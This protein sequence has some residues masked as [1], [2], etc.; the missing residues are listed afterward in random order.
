MSGL[1]KDGFPITVLPILYQSYKRS[2][3][4]V[5]DSIDI[6]NVINLEAF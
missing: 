6:P 1:V 3:L 4:L 5:H 2:F